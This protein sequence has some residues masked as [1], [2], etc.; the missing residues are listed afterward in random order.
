MASPGF[1][2]PLGLI[3]AQLNC[4]ALM[5]RDVGPA[6]TGDDLTRLVSHPRDVMN[7]VCRDLDDTAFFHRADLLQTY[8]WNLPYLLC[9][10]LALAEVLRDIILMSLQASGEGGIV[11]TDMDYSAKGLRISISDSSGHVRTSDERNDVWWAGSQ[12][13]RRLCALNSCLDDMGGTLVVAF[14]PDEGVVVEIYFPS[15]LC[16]GSA[17]ISGWLEGGNDRGQCGTQRHIP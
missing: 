8:R 12:R 15:S 9:D 6:D 11:I 16:L 17:M 1:T 5:L 3:V 4:L 10:P 13:Y 14:H 7:R 2:H